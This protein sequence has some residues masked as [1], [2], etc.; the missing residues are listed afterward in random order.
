MLREAIACDDPVIFL[1]SKHLYFRN[2]EE[3]DEAAGPLGFGARVARPGADLTVV[4][5]GRMTLRCLEVA[6]ALAADGLEV[7]VLDMRYIW[8]LDTE[9]VGTS[10]DKTSR[11]AVVHESVEFG[12]W[13]GEV[14]AWAAEHRFE[15]L[16]A[17]IVRVGSERSPVPV[18]QHLEDEV[19]PTTERIESALRELAAY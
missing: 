12:G 5:A 19:V 8:P 1:E 15:S 16:D 7:E 4:S 3:V 10:V 18:Q 17:P 6:E 14:A 11:L 2:A 13:G 9:A